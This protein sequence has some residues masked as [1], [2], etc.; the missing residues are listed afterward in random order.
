MELG[1]EAF[2]FRGA[3]FWL[4][5]NF[6]RLKNDRFLKIKVEL[7]EDTGGLFEGCAGSFL[8]SS[9]FLIIPQLFLLW[10]HFYFHSG[11]FL[12]LS[13]IFK[14]FLMLFRS[15]RRFFLISVRP[16]KDYNFEVPGA[17]LLIKQPLFDYHDDFSKIKISLTSLFDFLVKLKIFKKIV[18]TLP[19]I[20]KNSLSK[21]S[22]SLSK[23]QPHPFKNQNRPLTPHSYLIITL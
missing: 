20:K 17:L 7:F 5:A 14:I 3:L 16:F 1:F 21:T 10:W 6:L 12:N 4:S 13:E 11:A 8:I 2:F 23:R 15:R 19:S 9:V 18:V 22:R